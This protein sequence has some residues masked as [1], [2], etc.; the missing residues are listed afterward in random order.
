MGKLTF[1]NFIILLP[2]QEASELDIE[3]VLQ[4]LR[5]ERD[6]IDNAI[7]ALEASGGRGRR[8][9]GRKPANSR[10]GR[11]RLGARAKKRI[12]DAAKARWA[13]AKKAGKNRL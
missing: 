4:E 7:I 11:R 9:V 13:K 8:R 5:N 1:V 6:R 10:R 3:S 2:F 12:S